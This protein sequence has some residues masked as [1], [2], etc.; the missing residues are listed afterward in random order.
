MASDGY[1]NLDVIINAETG[2]FVN[3]AGYT[4]GTADLLRLFF[5]GRFLL[6]Q[7]YVDNNNQPFPLE[8]TSSFV[9][10]IDEG[11]THTDDSGTLQAN[12]PAG[13]Y[14]TI[15][16]VLTSD[17]PDSSGTLRLKKAGADPEDFVYTSWV[18]SGG[19]YTFTGASQALTESYV[20]GDEVAL[21]EPLMVRVENDQFNIAG[22]WSE[23]DLTAGKICCR[24]NCN[25]DEADA[26]LGDESSI[27]PYIEVTKYTSGIQSPILQDKCQFLNIVN[28]DGPAPA[29]TDP[30]YRTASAQDSIDNT[31]AD[32]VS[33]AT[34]NNLASLDSS[35][36]LLD[37]GVGVSDLVTDSYTETTL[38]DD[39]DNFITLG[40]AATFR[41]FVVE[42]IIT[43]GVNSMEGRTNV[44]HDGTDAQAQSEYQ[45]LPADISGIDLDIADINSGNVRLNV[46]CTSVGGGPKIQY[47]I[48]TSKPVTT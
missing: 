35:G 41:G 7:T 23:T 25:T 17:P 4:L 39:S 33:G 8:A 47:R 13:S 19:Y 22:D 29:S 2:K 38:T 30:L 26:R 44:I 36:N 27:K 32:K 34:A 3:S 5:K 21:L 18:D 48:L 12:R 20:I 11:F 28:D 43:L 9:L 46:K 40:A 24:I 1:K 14:T 16:V 42:W 37:S 15:P 31:K 45:Y 10:A 6:R